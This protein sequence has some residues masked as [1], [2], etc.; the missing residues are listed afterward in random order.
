M[1]VVSI[2]KEGKGKGKHMREKGTATK[3][4]YLSWNTRY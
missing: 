1:K 4:K 2:S 3:L